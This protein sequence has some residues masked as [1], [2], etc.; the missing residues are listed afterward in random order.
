M[1]RILMTTAII[2]GAMWFHH[3]VANAALTTPFA[4]SVTVS[5]NTDETISGGSFTDN[6]PLNGTMSGA[7][8]ACSR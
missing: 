8:S 1:K 7:R 6:V 2:A 4:D 3:P 5:G